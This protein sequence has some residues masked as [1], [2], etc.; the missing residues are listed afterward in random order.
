MTEPSEDHLTAIAEH[1]V[2]FAE[3]A[4]GNLDA[5]VEHCPG[6]NVADLVWHLTEVHWFW[7]T[8]AAERLTAPPDK[9]RRPK[10]TT[11]DALVDAFL[12]GSQRL[13]DVLRDADAAEQVWTWAPAQQNIGFITRH[14]V[15]EAA[16]HHWDAAN[17]AGRPLQIAIPVAVDA[18]DEFLTFSVSRET[19]PADPPRPPLGGT[20]ALQSTDAVRLRADNTATR[21]GAWT[22]TDGRAPGT[23]RVTQGAQAGVPTLDAHAS[24]LLLWLYGRVDIDTRSAPQDLLARFRALCFTD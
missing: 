13:V 9:S 17:A 20:F 23:V 7:G 2:G 21:C 1:S 11:D 15:Q 12:A 3:A 18:V 4:R 8:I 19:D 22:L 14:Q 24:D 5:A 10:R 6:W 16:V